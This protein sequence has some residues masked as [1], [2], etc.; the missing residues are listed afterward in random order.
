MVAPLG[1]NSRAMVRTHVLG[2]VLLP[3]EHVKCYGCSSSG[4]PIPWLQNGR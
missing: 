2:F 3:R 1:R 4:K